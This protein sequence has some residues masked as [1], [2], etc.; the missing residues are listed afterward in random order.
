[1]EAVESSAG[2][3]GPTLGGILFRLG[4]NVPLVSVVAIYSL[5]FVAIYLFYRDTIVKR[6]RRATVPATVE[7]VSDGKKRL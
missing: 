5:V 4:P 2:L 7:A 6:S 3:V 1:M